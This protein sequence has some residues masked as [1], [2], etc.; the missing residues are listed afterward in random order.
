[1]ADQ[2]VHALL[3]EDHPT[4]M[5]LVQEASIAVTVSEMSRHSIVD[6]DEKPILFTARSWI[7][8]SC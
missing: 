8:M 7:G 4:N 5:L 3:V 6:G 2:A 1:M